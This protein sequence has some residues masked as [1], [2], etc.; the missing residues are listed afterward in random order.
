VLG[1]DVL[2][3]GNIFLTLV[4]VNWLTTAIESKKMERIAEEIKTSIILSI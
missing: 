1:G 2:V 3:I 4:V